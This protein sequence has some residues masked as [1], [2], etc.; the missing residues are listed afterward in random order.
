MVHDVVFLEGDL[1]SYDQGEFCCATSIKLCG[2]YENCLEKGSWMSAASAVEVIHNTVCQQQL[3]S[4]STGAVRFGS[5][6]AVRFGSA[7]AVRFGSAGAVR[8]GSAGAVRFGSAGAVRF[9]SA[10]AVRFGSAGAV[11]FGSAGAVRFGSAGAV[12]FGLGCHYKVPPCHC[13]KSMLCIYMYAF[14]GMIL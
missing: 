12:R 1:L 5:A 2:S 14:P 6:G 11:R 8:F 9:G 13:V 4:G 3:T 10:G 7:G